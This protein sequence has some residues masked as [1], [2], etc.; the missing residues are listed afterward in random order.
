MVG[1]LNNYPLPA[2]RPKEDRMK[3]QKLKKIEAKARLGLP[4]SNEE[5]AYYILHSK[6]IDR[7]VVKC[8]I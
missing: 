1:M 2:E 5:K 4:I 3:K 7:E 6:I 8:S